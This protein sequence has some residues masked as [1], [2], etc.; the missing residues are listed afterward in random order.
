[1]LLVLA[2]LVL[3][4]NSPAGPPM[5]AE[6]QISADEFKQVVRD[7]REVVLASGNVVVTADGSEL[8]APEA[9][10]DPATGT[11][12]FLGTSTLTSRLPAERIRTRRAARG[13]PE[14]I[15][16]TVKGTDAVY[17][18]NERRGSV[19]DARASV[20]ELNLRGSQIA[21]AAGQVLVQD[22][23]ITTCS[24]EKPHYALRASQAQ[25]IPGTKAIVRGASLTVG[26]TKLLGLP[27]LNINLRRDRTTTG[28]PLPALGRSRLSGYYL[29][30]LF[31]FS[32]GPEASADLQVDLAT[33]AGLRGSALVRRD[34]PFTPFLRVSTKE[35]LLGRRPK[36]VL[37]TR[38]PEAGFLL[39]RGALGG[40]L[41]ALQAEASVGWF[42]ERTTRTRTSRLYIDLQLGEPARASVGRWRGSLTGA[43][44]AAHYG[45]G[46]DYRD[47][48]ASLTAARLIGK[49]DSF[50]VGLVKHFLAG[51]TPF[52]FDEAYLPVEL[53][54]HIELRRGLYCF[55][56]GTR[57]DLKES[58]LFDMRIGVGRVYHCLEPRLVWRGR[59]RELSLEVHLV[60]SLQNSRSD[61][62][63]THVE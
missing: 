41:R 40:S 51:R 8:R 16:V 59:L 31:P 1:M 61:A 53:N 10:W 11:I 47:L 25:V 5:P 56:V 9:E 6:A 33:R 4:L 27:Q 30:W 54:Q 32:I 46:E 21:V 44:R 42:D 7:G 37:V 57:F 13:L 38:A 34:S 26:G 58:K 28:L 20:Q 29:R 55:E 43:L 2:N 50:Q 52:V 36:R 62:E 60:P 19:R 24:L 18:V 48:S 14:T 49:N 12:K 22:A 15:L 23:V 3:A 35:E 45:S 39:E 17:S 63:Q